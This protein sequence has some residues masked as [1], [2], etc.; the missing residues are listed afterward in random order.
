MDNMQ[1][2]GSRSATLL[3]SEPNPDDTH[4]GTYEGE[5]V[6]SQADLARIIQRRLWV[7]ALVGIIFA[8]A[9]AGFALM[10]TPTYE[11]SIKIMIRQERSGD[12]PPDLGNEVAGLQQLTGIMVEAVQ[13]GPVAQSAIQRLDLSMSQSDFLERLSAEQIGTTSFIEVTY[14]DAS[15][16]RA[17]RIANTVGEVFSDKVSETSP[18]ANP[19]VATLWE[20]AIL[21]DSPANPT[22]LRDT[23]LALT[24]GLMLGAGLAFLLEYLDKSRKA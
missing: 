7:V 19:I 13:T 17:Q 23:L 10:Q 8:G 5:L 9:A 14:T 24:L 1:L 18:S 21:P 6:L 4:K 20:R 3:A 12:T 11:A 22:T 2:K 15:P 16:A